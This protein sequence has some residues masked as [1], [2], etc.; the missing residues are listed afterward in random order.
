MEIVEYEFKKYYVED[1]RDFLRDFWNE[2]E[3][4]GNIY[5]E[6]ERRRYGRTEAYCKTFLPKIGKLEKIIL[7]SFPEIY[8]HNYGVI[9]HDIEFV[10]DK[11]KIHCGKNFYWSYKGGGPG[12]FHTLLE[13]LGLDITYDEIANIP[14]ELKDPF[15]IHLKEKKK[16][17]IEDPDDHWIWMYTK[18]SINYCRQNLSKIGKINKVVLSIPPDITWGYEGTKII[19]EDG[20]I[21]CFGFGWGLD[22][23]KSRALLWLLKILGLDVDMDYIIKLS[24]PDIRV[25]FTYIYQEFLVMI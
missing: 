4:E 20:I 21:L 16:Y 3:F 2:S 24:K 22:Y 1:Y 12:D 9:D 10:G 11:G 23:F 14:R 5:Y 19:G 25:P 13:L 8:I 6:Y 15:E 7:R 17:F 18:S